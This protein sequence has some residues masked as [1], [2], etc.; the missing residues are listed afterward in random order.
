MSDDPDLGVAVMAAPLPLASSTSALVATPAAARGDR[1]NVSR[2]GS[3]V[4]VCTG[5]SRS[6]PTSDHPD[7]TETLLTLPLY[8]VDRLEP[9]AASTVLGATQM[10]M[11]RVLP[12]GGVAGAVASGALASQRTSA[13]SV[14]RTPAASVPGLDPSRPPPR[15]PTRRAPA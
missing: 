8:V 1:A 14:R 15:S 3:A 10:G 9:V 5:V 7:L 4:A 12:L 6:V 2:P 11:P 13:S